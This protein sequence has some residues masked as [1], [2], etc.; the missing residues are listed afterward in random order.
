L[1]QA[2]VDRG[3]VFTDDTI[4]PMK[5]TDLLRKITLKYRIWIYATNDQR[6]LKI[7]H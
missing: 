7:H 1:K 6:G 5:N 3:H 4:L 2:V